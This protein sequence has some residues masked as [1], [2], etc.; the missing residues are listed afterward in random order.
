[1]GREIPLAVILG[2][3]GSK[4]SKNEQA[5]FKETNP[6]GLILFERNC[7]NPDQVK[8]LTN[9][10]RQVI[11]QEGAPVFIDQEGGASDPS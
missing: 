11:G 9:E 10:F 3:A 7:V 5:L 2:C 1:M 6:F 4:L 8:A